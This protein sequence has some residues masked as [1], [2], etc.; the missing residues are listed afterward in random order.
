MGVFTIYLNGD[1][2]MKIAVAG[3]GKLGIKVIEALLSGDHS[4]TII[5]TQEQLLDKLMSQMDVLTVNANAKDIKVLKDIDIQTFDYLLA[6]TG[7]DEQ[8][9]LIASFA[10]K[11]G[12]HKVI[13]SVR[14]PEH[15]NQREF[16]METMGIDFIVN[17]D[18]SIAS[19]IYK[20]LVEKYTLSN[21]IFTADRISLVEFAAKRI[22][23]LIGLPLTEFGTVLENMIVVAISSEFGKVIVPHGDTVIKEQDILYVI[24]ET[25]AVSKLHDKVLDRGS[26]YTDISKIMIMGGGKTGLYLARMLE[27]FGNYV[28][29]VEIDEK[30]CHYLAS[31]LNSTVILNGDA[32]DLTL[33]E[34]E[35]I[36]GMDALITVTGYDEENLL[37]ALTAKQRGVEDVIA[38]ISHRSYADLIE[39][40]GLDMTLNPLD[41]TAS[42]ILRF[43]QGSKR[44]LS[45]VLVQGQAE[46]IEI[47][48]ESNMPIA[49]KPLKNLKLPKGMIIAA[50]HRG[51]EIEIPN[52][53]TVLRN[54]DR[55]MILY[56][57]S[58]IKDLEKLIKTSSNRFFSFGS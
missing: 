54:G 14:D 2:Q 42:S 38:K 52:G 7:S 25:K 3:A 43:I 18:Y 55:V 40:I 32:T 23:G 50:L 6:S 16:I 46:L 4:I 26:K 53:N 45:S 47:I 31:Y 17:P 10:R 1:L 12:C 48:V 57:L 49:N 58:E 22:P 9:I 37:L 35:N 13:A 19:E 39:T 51:T 8:N 36:D 11:L 33:W 44:I 30:R 24:G 34:D 56:L 5:D 15:M 28:K 29:I 21:G 27:Q 41:I 20:Y